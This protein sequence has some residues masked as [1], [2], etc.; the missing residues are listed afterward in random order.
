MSILDQAAELD[1][2]LAARGYDPA[3]RAAALAALAAS[4]A[5]APPV[6]WER[7]ELELFEQYGP[8]LRAKG[9]LRR[10]QHAARVLR[11]LGVTSPADLGDVRLITRLVATRDPALSPNTVKG[12]LQR[13][14]TI[15]THAVNLGYLA[16]SPFAA[17]PLRTWV[18]GVKPK[19]VRHLTKVQM[20]ALLDLLAADVR[21][22]KGWAL[23]RA[24]RLQALVVLIS[25]TGL[26]KAEALWCQVEDLDL[27]N[28][29]VYVKSRST[30]R[31][32][33]V[34]S[35]AYVTCP[36]A[37]VAIL[38]QWLLHRTDA[39]PGWNRTNP[40]LFPNLKAPT[41]WTQ[42][43]RGQKPLHRLQ[44][45]A[46]RAGLVDEDGNA[47]ASFQVLRRSVGTHMEANGAAASQI[48][49]QL[50]HSNVSTTQN[51]YM[52]RD[53]ENMG[54]VMEGFGYD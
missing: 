39:P 12:L 4:P 34:G 6:P 49:R 5:A 42:G 18:R 1:Q 41:P 48:Q 40:Y 30:H 29:V 38:R 10:I 7:F 50:R 24:R 54:R 32:K 20:K 53:R 9:T 52:E 15:T 33:T 35:E 16:T 45:A 11:E 13:V 8:S 17:R 14:Q 44:A 43:S 25:Y 19:G 27:D 28:G 36:P 22:R 46:K 23:W 51:W 31:L 2:L 21:D 47:L 3:A 26:R 37:A